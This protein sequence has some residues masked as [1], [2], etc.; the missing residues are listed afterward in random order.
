MPPCRVIDGMPHQVDPGDVVHIPK[1]VHH[2]TI[3]DTGEEVELICFFPHP[4]LTGNYQETDMHVS[5]E[6]HS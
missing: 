5:M 4:E 6:E 1:G 2:A 3:A